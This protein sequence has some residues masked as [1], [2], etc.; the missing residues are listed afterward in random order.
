[1]FG[2]VMVGGGDKLVFEDVFVS[3]LS[4]LF[5]CALAGISFS[6]LEVGIQSPAS[7]SP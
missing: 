6:G 2:T 5:D 4:A 1:M 3:F 7:A